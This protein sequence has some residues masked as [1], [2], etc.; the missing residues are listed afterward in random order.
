MKNTD[1]CLE[2]LRRAKEGFAKLFE[3][4]LTKELFEPIL[5]ETLQKKKREFILSQFAGLSVEELLILKERSTDWD[6]VEKK[7]SEQP[8]APVVKKRRGRQP[9]K[10]LRT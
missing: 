7:P 2:L 3:E 4:T 5:E 6:Q 8:I 9:Y 1:D 10:H